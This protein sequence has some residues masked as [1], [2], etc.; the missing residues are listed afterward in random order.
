[1]DIGYAL[2]DLEASAQLV[3]EAAVTEQQAPDVI[4][5]LKHITSRLTDHTRLLRAETPEHVRGKAYTTVPGKGKW[6]RSYNT[7]SLLVTFLKARGGDLSALFKELL[8]EKAITLGWRWS[9][10]E[11]YAARH[12]VTLRIVK[13][14]EV[15]DGDP[16]GDV[17]QIW[18]VGPT[19]VTANREGDA[20]D[21]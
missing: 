8:A 16:D 18:K 3:V 5:R 20:S 21:D 12:G 9:D 17:G 19:D 11:K 13:G 2:D 14:R 15:A 4:G 6:D 10:L 7:Q 1:M